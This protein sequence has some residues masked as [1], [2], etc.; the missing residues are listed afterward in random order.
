MDLAH[1]APRPRSYV[2]V[3]GVDTEPLA[4]PSLLNARDYCA[5]GIGTY[6]TVQSITR[7]DRDRRLWA[8]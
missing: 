5:L 8:S 2:R 3:L 4:V 6:F 1:A 7:Y